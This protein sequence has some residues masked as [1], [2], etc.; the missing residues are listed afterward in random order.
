MA[1]SPTG[2]QSRDPH[3]W[4][5]VVTQVAQGDE[6]ALARFYD[7]TSRMVF[8]LV[9]RMVGESSVA[10]DITLEVY[11]QVWRTAQ[12]Y[13]PARGTVTAWLITLARTRAIDWTR[14][15][16]ARSRQRTGNLEKIPELRD[17]APGPEIASIEWDRK[18]A[19]QKA[20]AGLSEDQR[21]VIELSYFEAMSH[22]EIAQRLAQPLGTVKSRIRSGMSRM[23]ELLNPIARSFY[24]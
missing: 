6:A 22:S 2:A 23:R 17:S 16:Q 12:S 5:A 13:S 24:E 9:M 21:Q 18:Q 3:D 4:A 15:G 10:E 14:S 11:M 7:G 1:A 8:G 19:V 20:L